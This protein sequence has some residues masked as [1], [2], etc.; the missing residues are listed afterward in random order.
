MRTAYRAARVFDGLHMSTSSGRR[1]VVVEDDT[2]LEVTGDRAPAGCSVLDLDGA[3]IM[4]GLVDAHVHLVWD[5]SAAPER[6]VTAESNVLTAFRTAR[7]AMAHLRAGVTALRDLG[8]AGGIAA[9]VA[10][11]VRVRLVAGPRIVASGSAIT[12]AND[13]ACY[14]GCGGT[15]PGCP[16]PIAS[17]EVLVLK[18]A[19]AEAHHAGQTVAAHAHSSASIA[20]A[21]TAGV[22]SI[23]HGSQPDPPTAK[24][25]REQNVYLVP[26][27]S[28]VHSICRDGARLGLPAD[29]LVAAEL[30]LERNVEAFRTAVRNEVPLAAGTDAGVPTQ[31]HGVLWRELATMAR[32]GCPPEIVLRAATHGGAELLGLGVTCGQI[33]PGMRADLIAVDG[34]PRADL[35]VLNRPALVLFGGTVVAAETSGQFG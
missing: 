19:V 35:S 12:P 15:D 33:A 23:E 16:G 25:M 4:P 18:T 32:L 34:D 24:Q 20:I 6:R 22:N 9:Q 11:A 29:V 2:I 1:T 7:N 3:T 5:S 10:E 28:S 21:L 13:Q 8:S 31:P 14:V 17:E 30:M 27:L 26:T